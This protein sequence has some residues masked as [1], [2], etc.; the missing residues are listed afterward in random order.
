MNCLNQ[1][2]IEFLDQNDDEEF[3]EDDET[4]STFLE[5]YEDC[6]HIK[7]LIEIIEE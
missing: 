7:S 4:A 3:I 5:D 1:L 2:Y 6:I